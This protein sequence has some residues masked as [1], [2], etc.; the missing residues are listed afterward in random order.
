MLSEGDE[1]TMR[2]EDFVALSLAAHAKPGP[3]HAPAKSVDLEVQDV[4]PTG[5]GGHVVFL[6]DLDN[7][8]IVPI[9]VGESEAIAI[10]YRLSVAQRST[11]EVAVDH[12][13]WLRDGDDALGLG[14]W[15]TLVER[16]DGIAVLPHALQRGHEV[17]PGR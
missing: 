9:H 11:F 1:M 5:D 2:P 14:G 4:T 7:E 6:T 13:G 16:E 10:A 8:H 3:L 15:E 12:R 17:G